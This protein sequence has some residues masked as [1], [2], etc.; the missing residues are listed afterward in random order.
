MAKTRVAPKKTISVA[1]LELQAAL[2][3][4]LAP[5]KAACS[6]NLAT[7]VLAKELTIPIRRRKFWT[8]SSCV[9]NWLRTTASHYKPFVSHRIGEIQTLTESGEWRF[10]PGTQNP[11]D[12]GTRSTLTGDQARLDRRSKILQTHQA[13]CLII[14]RWILHP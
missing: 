7:K 11:A 3:A 2:L 9:W 10:V 4:I 6:S 13:Y 5:S 1:K 12:W 8:N 14:Y